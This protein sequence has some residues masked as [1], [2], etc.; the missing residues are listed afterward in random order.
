MEFREYINIV[1]RYRYPVLGAV[2]LSVLACLYQLSTSVTL[3]QIN[4][5]VR[6]NLP[7]EAEQVLAPGLQIQSNMS[8]DTALAVFESPD[9]ERRI[10]ELNPALSATEARQSISYSEKGVPQR[11]FSWWRCIM[12]KNKRVPYYRWH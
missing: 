8:Y 11:A 5:E 7:E 6:I 4:A 3:Y 10:G 12:K 1:W 9:W 2:L